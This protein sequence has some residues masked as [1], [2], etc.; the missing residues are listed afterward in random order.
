MPGMGMGQGGG[1]AISLKN[2][3]TFSSFSN[4]VFRLYYTGMLGQMAAMNMQLI[5]K[6]LLIYQLTGSGTILGVMALAN[7]LPMLVFSL[8]GGV[9][10]DR[11]EKRKVLVLGQTASGIVSLLI[12][13]ALT[14][15]YM[16]PTVPGSWI[17]LVIAALF[18][19]IIQGLMM[20]SRQAMISDIVSTR[21]LMNAIALNTFGQ[22]ILRLVAPALAGFFI[23]AFGFDAVYYAMTGMYLMAAFFV[24][25]MPVTG[26]I[27]LRGQGAWASMKDGFTYVRRENTVF[28]VL[29]LTLIMVL[30]SMPYL[31]LLPAFTE[32]ILHVGSQ[33]LGIMVSVSGIGA[34]AGSVV[35]ASLPNKR[36][37][38]LLMLSG[39]VLG[40]ALVGFSF[41][42]SWNLSLVMI[43][44]VGLGQTGRMTLSNTLLQYYVSDEYR[45]RVMSIYMMEF[46]LTSLSVFIAGVLSDTIGVQWAVGGLAIGLV[47]LSALMLIFAPKV[48]DLD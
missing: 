35:L 34:M 1:G 22:N 23:A 7:S 27:S 28:A 29:A 48:R 13:V 4:P 18:Q 9:I 31:T 20:P 40:L 32:D 5:A 44:F 26:T 38:L 15:G 43:V 11:V 10:A 42:N 6:G 45:G 21:D 41:S 12:A 19:G 2:L 39:L 46:G 33:G 24:F 14:L 3:R 36:R 37:G 16:G 30:L 17:V 47:A 25:L 8:F